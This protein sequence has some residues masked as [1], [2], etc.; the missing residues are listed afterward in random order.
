MQMRL[1]IRH[2]ARSGGGRQAE[3][4]G[5]RREAPRFNHLGKYANGLEAIHC[6]EFRNN[7]LTDG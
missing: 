4:P 3:L 7:L 1:Q 6:T 2:V 5:R